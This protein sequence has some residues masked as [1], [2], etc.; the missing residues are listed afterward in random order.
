VPCTLGLTGCIAKNTIGKNIGTP[1]SMYA[2]SYPAQCKQWLSC[3]VPA[4]IWMAVD[5]LAPAAKAGWIFANFAYAANCFV[6]PAEMGLNNDYRLY[7]LA[8]KRLGYDEYA[9][10]WRIR[11]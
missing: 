7:S 10:D 9:G 1:E 11:H 2:G 8:H 4:V 5:G 6:C 3:F